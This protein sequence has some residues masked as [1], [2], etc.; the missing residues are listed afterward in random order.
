M[1]ESRNAKS[2]GSVS[3]TNLGGRGVADTRRMFQS[4]WAASCKPA[5]RA[6]R[7]SG[8]GGGGR[9]GGGGGGGA[10]EGERGAGHGQGPVKGGE[11]NPSVRHGRLRMKVGDHGFPPP[12]GRVAGNRLLRAESRG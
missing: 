4:A 9:G 8:L 6:T 5:R 3:L 11:V 1:S 10:G 12:G 2:P 7:G